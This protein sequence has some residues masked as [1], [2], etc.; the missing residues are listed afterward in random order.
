MPKDKAGNF[1]RTFQKARSADSMSAPKKA[2]P[3]EDKENSPDEKPD[4]GGEEQTHT[5]VGH[6]D[7]TAHTEGPEG[8][9]EHASVGHALAHVGHKL[10]GGKH[11]HMHHS[12]GS[13]HSA[14]MSD[15]GPHEAEHDSPEEAG[16][17]AGS[18]M[19]DENSEQVEPQHGESEPFAGG[20][21]HGLMGY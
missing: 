8:H 17:D 6:A 21:K 20:A 3:M 19:A 10:S 11:L 14:G 2:S 15:N 12:G 1:H 4:N 7:G 5:V 18:Y 9:E 13:I 16:S